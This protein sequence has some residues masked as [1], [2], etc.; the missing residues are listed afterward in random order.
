MVSR[1]HDTKPSFPKSFLDILR[2]SDPV[3]APPQPCNNNAAKSSKLRISK[4]AISTFINGFESV[5]WRRFLK[6]AH[7]NG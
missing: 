2:H 6:L 5:E 3:D 7:P 1:F 4:T